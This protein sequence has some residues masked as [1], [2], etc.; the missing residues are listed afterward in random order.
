MLVARAVQSGANADQLPQYSSGSLG[1]AGLEI[2]YAARANAFVIRSNGDVAKCT[3]AF[4]DDRNKIGRL[5]PDGEL[6][7]DH[8][9]HLPWLAGLMTGDPSELSCPALHVIWGGPPSSPV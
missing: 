1:E 8:N 2:C 3:V 6:Q 7:V 4:T 9:R 5:T